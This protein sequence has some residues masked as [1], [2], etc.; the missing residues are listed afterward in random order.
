M[1]GE[2]CRSPSPATQPERG[3]VDDITLT[4]IT[5]TRKIREDGQQVF[6]VGMEREFSFVEALGLLEAAKW[7]I[8]QRMAGRP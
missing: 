7:D 2:G 4:E 5:I 8:C 3:A 6:S 1:A